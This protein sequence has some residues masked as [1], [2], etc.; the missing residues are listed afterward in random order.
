MAAEEPPAKVAK[1]E[2][3]SYYITIDGVKYDRKLLGHI[4]EFGKS[5]GQISRAEAKKIWEEAKD[6]EGVTDCERE[7]IKYSMSK[8][9]FTAAATKS[10]NIYLEGGK[11]KSYYKV[12]KGTRYDRELL[13]HA[14]LL[15]ADGQLSV[16]DVKTVVAEAEDG[17]GITGT[18]RTT[19]EYIAKEMKLTAKAR[20]WFEEAIKLPTP[21]SYIKQIDGVKYDASLLLEIEQYASD[22]TISLAEAERMWK[23]AEDGRGVTDTEK[24]TLKYAL[25]TQGSKFTAPASEFLKGKLAPLVKSEQAV[26][27]WD[28]VSASGYW[29]DLTLNADYTA[30][31]AGG[32]DGS[33]SVVD[34]DAMTIN[35]QRTCD[36]ANRHLYT[37][38]D[39]GSELFLRGCEARTEGN[40]FKKAKKKEA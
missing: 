14:D 15:Q 1:T 40:V 11:H 12:I 3:E 7:T 30:S 10:M 24:A 32:P 38:T 37:L 25:D 35:L 18:E 9:K 33:W 27:Q 5:G 17:K 20:E 23:S 13:E 28:I 36:G 31:W 22:G 19:L 29:N 16:L 39:E 26:G 34:E 6:G 2:E 8:Y 21:T 4:E